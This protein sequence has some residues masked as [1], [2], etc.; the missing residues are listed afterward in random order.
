MYLRLDKEAEF[1]RMHIQFA[2]ENEVNRVRVARVLFDGIPRMIST[3]E[4]WAYQGI[5]FESQSPSLVAFMD[6]MKFVHKSGDD[7]VL[8]FEANHVRA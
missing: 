7:Y 4:A 6:R 5:I 3:L 1:V 8:T 2:P